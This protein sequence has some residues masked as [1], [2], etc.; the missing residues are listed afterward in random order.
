MPE[1][2]SDSHGTGMLFDLTGTMTVDH[3]F[4]GNLKWLGKNFD[5]LTP[6]QKVETYKKTSIAEVTVHDLAIISPFKARMYYED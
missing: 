5:D 3:N 1:T 4:T 6:E 2:F